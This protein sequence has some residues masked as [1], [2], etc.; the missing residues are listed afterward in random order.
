[1][2]VAAVYPDLWSALGVNGPDL[3]ILEK[4][5]TLFSVFDG[6]THEGNASAASMRRNSPSESNTL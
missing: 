3:I 6:F 5:R 1:M 2:D 4:V